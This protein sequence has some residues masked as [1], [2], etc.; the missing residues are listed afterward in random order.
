MVRRRGII[1]SGKAGAPYID[2]FCGPGHAKSKDSTQYVDGAALYE[3]VFK[4]VARFDFSATIMPYDRGDARTGHY[5]RYVQA[6][7]AS[8][9]PCRGGARATKSKTMS[10]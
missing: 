10:L 4:F 2:L 5:C 3:Q 9:C 6:R 7:R 1:G 8:R